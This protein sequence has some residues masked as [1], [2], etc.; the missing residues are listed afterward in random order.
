M[1]SKLP[2]YKVY[3]RIA[4]SKIHGVGVI[5]ICPI[6]KG[7]Y[8][9]YGDDEKLRWIKKGSLRSISKEIKKLYSDFCIK[10]GKLY[11]CP[12]NFNKMTPAWYLNHP[13]NPNAASDHNYRFYA[14]KN[15]KKGEE[16]TVDYRTYSERQGRHL[17]G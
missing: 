16:I 8:I 11:G 15:I 17:K 14:L 12:Q 5:A 6:K 9:F 10:R 3:T 2:H 13:T 1:I 7:T 4:R